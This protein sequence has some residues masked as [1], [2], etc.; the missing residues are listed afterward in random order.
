MDERAARVPWL[1]LLP[2]DGHH[3]V[4]VFVEQC[5]AEGRGVYGF[6]ELGAEGADVIEVWGDVLV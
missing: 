6:E 5:V 2:E 1:D 4:R 3:A